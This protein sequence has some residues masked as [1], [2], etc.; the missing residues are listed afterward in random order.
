MGVRGS[1]TVLAVCAA[2]AA[3]ATDAQKQAETMQSGLEAARQGESACLAQLR[4]TPAVARVLTVLAL[5]E[6]DP[7]KL[8]KLSDPRTADD[9]LR[10]DLVE[11]HQA[12]LPCRSTL[13]NGLAAVHPS[14]VEVASATFAAQDRVLLGLLNGQLT[15]GAANEGFLEINR[16]SR[17]AWLQTSGALDQQLADAHAAEMQQRAAVAM[18]LQQ[19]SVQQQMVESMNRPTTTNCTAIGNMLNCQ[20]F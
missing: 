7:A 20:P 11:A 8:H 17:A 1:L 3:C 13:K 6:D 18:A 16:L 12:V 19:W 9:D 2:L 10:R 15:I 5:D 14:Y 4:G